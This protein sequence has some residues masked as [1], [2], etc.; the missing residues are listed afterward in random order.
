MSRAVQTAI[1]SLN[2]F[3][4]S[5]NAGNII[6]VVAT[7]TGSF[8]SNDQTNLA[9]NG[10]MFFVTI[11]SVTVNTVTVQMSINAKDVQSGAYFP[12][13]KASLDGLA[14]GTTQGILTVYPGAGAGT[15]VPAN[16]AAI[17]MPLPNVFQVVASLTIT[18]TASMSGTVGYSVD[19]GKVH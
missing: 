1:D 18:T 2:F 10:G 3:V 6:S 14:P 12:Y 9:Q 15:F 11:A 17:G 4:E 8:T 5:R 16:G 7:A 13:I 19:Y